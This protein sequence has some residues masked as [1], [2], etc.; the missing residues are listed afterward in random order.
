MFAEELVNES[1]SFMSAK[2]HWVDRVK[3]RVDELK[4]QENDLQNKEN[5]L[6]E[7]E[8]KLKMWEEKMKKQF[9]QQVKFNL[10]I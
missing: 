5:E 10:I 2:S 7:R 3:S 6:N 4:Q 8:Q 9:K 1:N